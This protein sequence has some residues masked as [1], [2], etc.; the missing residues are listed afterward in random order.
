[1]VTAGRAVVDG[2]CCL[3]QARMSEPDVARR[4]GIAVFSGLLTEEGKREKGKFERKPEGL[5]WDGGENEG[6]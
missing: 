6:Q 3:V 1:M 5:G 4:G 2:S